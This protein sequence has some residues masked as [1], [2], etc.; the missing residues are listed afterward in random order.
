MAVGAHVT[1]APRPPRYMCLALVHFLCNALVG[2]STLQGAV[3]R[4]VMS[5]DELIEA[6]GVEGLAREAA[7]EAANEVRRHWLEAFEG[8]LANSTPDATNWMWLANLD[9]E[10]RRLRRVL[11]IKTPPDVVRQQTRERVRRHR[12][13]KRVRSV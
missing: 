9:S 11:G 5:W 2:I 13:R 3:M 10:V 12:E 4:L 6:G 8:M 1:R 7:E